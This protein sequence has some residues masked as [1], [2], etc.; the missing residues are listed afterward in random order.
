MFRE[1]YILLLNIKL[2]E[3]LLGVS[4]I[5]LW[6]EDCEIILLYPRQHLLGFTYNDLLPTHYSLMQ[7]DGFILINM[8]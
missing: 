7:S 5:I 4:N 6:W 3:W 2:S 1:C 8:S